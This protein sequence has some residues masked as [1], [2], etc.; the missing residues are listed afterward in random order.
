[1]YLISVYLQGSV[2]F[3]GTSWNTGIPIYW[4]II[5]IDLNYIY[6]HTFILI[7]I[8]NMKYNQV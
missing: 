1:M 5:E 3:T 7:K 8:S 2:I 4:N 6:V